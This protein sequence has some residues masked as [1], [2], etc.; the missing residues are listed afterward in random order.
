LPPTLAAATGGWA[1]PGFEPVLS[2][3]ARAA[4]DFGEV[5]C[6]VSAWVGGSQVVNAWTGLGEGRPWREDTLAVT[7]SCTKGAVALCAQML[8]DRGLLDPSRRVGDYWPEFATAGKE[9][10]TVGQL[11]DH[12]AGVLTIPDYPTLLGPDLGGLTDWELVTTALAAS[13]PAWRPGT[14]T[15]YHAMTYGHLA[16]EAIRRIDGR[17]PGRFF[18]DEVAVPLGLEF[19]IGLPGDLMERVAGPIAEPGALVSESDIPPP[20]LD[21]LRRGDWLN[22]AAWG[23]STI[24]QYPGH[25]SLFASLREQRMLQAELPAI[26]GTGTASA[27]GRMYAA[28]ALGGELDGVRLVSPESTERA[29]APRTQVP[30]SAPYGLG[31][32]LFGELLSPCGAGQRS[33]GH[34]GAGGNLAFADPDAGVGFALVKNRHFAEPTAALALVRSLYDCL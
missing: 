10:T 17:T 26:N 27:L 6:A 30:F 25:A 14:R 12:S 19:W 16:G 31:Y 1:R 24:F 9:E 33:F 3:L 21:A 23:W 32:Q 8:E 22:E 18:H 13:P 5:G 7:F 2:T 34:A 29:I 20:A 4:P 15:G 11:L 28:L